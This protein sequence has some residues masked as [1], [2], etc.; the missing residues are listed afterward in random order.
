MSWVELERREVLFF[1]HTKCIE[2]AANANARRLFLSS[3]LFSEEEAG[4]VFL[5]VLV[6]CL[7][8]ARVSELLPWLLPYPTR[9]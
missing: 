7:I 2:G 5:Q 8:R 9:D 1:L 6:F 3:R 4:R